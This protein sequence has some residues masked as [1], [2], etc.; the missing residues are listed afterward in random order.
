M[1]WYILYVLCG[2]EEMVV[3]ALK[4]EDDFLAFVPKMEY[5]R[6]DQKKV[7]M[8]AMFPGYVFVKTK[9]APVEF[10]KALTAVRVQRQRM[11]KELTYEDATSLKPQEV[12]YFENLLD[13]CGLMK[14]STGII[15][16]RKLKILDG[17]LQHYENR[18]VKVDKHERMA[19]LDLEFMKR[20]IKAAFQ[21]VN[22]TRKQ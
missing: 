20:H 17:P 5:Y 3:T 12:A 1:N 2:N 10:H 22:D 13:E 8:K 14:M 6:R 7:A 15:E 9:L 18:I 11:M 4:Q 21:L 16:D 19:Y